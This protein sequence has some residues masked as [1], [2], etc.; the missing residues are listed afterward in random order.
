MKSNFLIDYLACILFRILG[1]IFRFLPVEWSLCLGRLAGGCFYYFDFKHK[2]RS[3]ANIK[4]ALGKELPPVKIAKLTKEFYQSF[5]QSLMEIFLI[6]KVDKSYMDKYIHIEGLTNIYDGLEKGKGVILIAIHA[7]S[8]ELA[9]IICAN[10]GFPFYLF[11]KDQ[12]FPRLNELLNK[13]RRQKGCKIITKEGGLKQL[14]EALKN[15]SAVGI[16]LDQGGKTGELVDF[17]GRSA[18]MSTGGIKLALKYGC[19]VV[20]VYFKR[21]DGPNI[22]V[23]V[24]KELELSKTGKPDVDLKDNLLKFTKYFE[25]LI[26][27]YPKEY[28]WTYKIWK[29]SDQRSILILSDGKAGH[30]R[31]SECVSGI[32]VERLQ[33]R[34]IQAK[35]DIL[36]VKFKNRL[37]KAVFSLSSLLAGKYHCQGCLYCLKKFLDEDTYKKL[38]FLSPD[39]VVSCGSS[40]AAVNFIIS[41]ENLS[42]SVVVMRPSILSVKRFDLVIMPRHDHPPQRK[43]VVVTAGSLNPVNE[44][45]L[46]EEAGKLIQ[47]VSLNPQ[48]AYIG[49][50]IGG[51]SKRFVLGDDLIRRVITEVK[52]AADKINAGILLTT[53]RRTRT[54]AEDLIKQEFKDYSRCKLMVIANDK[55]IPEAVGG[56]LGLSKV[57]ASSAAGKSMISEAVNSA[58]SVVVFR[59]EGLSAKHRVFVENLSRSKHIILSAVDSL[60]QKIEEAW[61]DKAAVNVLRDNDLVAKAVEKIL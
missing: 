60:G 50:L 16:T 8:W 26:R 46:K 41:R 33:N 22:Q 20:P 51:D 23:L 44:Q 7:G 2:A 40:L 37:A 34:G 27:R 15:N 14:I 32:V 53:S 58:K 18:S 36:E 30:L 39:M 9:N 52:K 55:N 24:G 3:Y 12:D 57:I 42:K 47:R 19:P 1:A 45:Y 21:T 29:Y 56:I 5:G 6:P 49:V 28:L 4:I 17:F 61:Q 38:S 13:Y 10:L 43:N 48:A 54:Q 31:Q 59:G 25:E 35:I 11:V